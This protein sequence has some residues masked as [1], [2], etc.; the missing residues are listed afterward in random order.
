M[1][2]INLL[3]LYGL[4]WNPF[5]MSIP[6]EG[7]ANM[8]KL[9]SF[10][11]RVE[12]LVMDGGFAM[13]TGLPGTGKSVTLRMLADRLSKIPEVQ[14]GI[15]CRPQSGIADFYRELGEHFGVELRT[16]NRWGGFKGLREKWKQHIQSTLF[17]PVLLIDEAQE[18][19]PFVL[20]ELRHLASTD[21]DSNL[22]LTTVFCGDLRLQDKFRLPDLIPLGSRI[23]V[24]HQTGIASKEELMD[25]L[26]TVTEKAGN[27]HLMTKELVE[28]LAEH[29]MGNL[30]AM[31]NMA[32]TILLEGMVQEAPKLDEKLFFELYTPSK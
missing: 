2:R 16:S 5:N 8:K 7:L 28:L 6:L 1:D 15:L 12:N 20:N 13:I 29:G 9:D 21:F 11:W 17:R 31:M 24:R 27:K 4:K 10:C 26:K 18:A 23:N 25:V 3:N 22:I 30:R 32:S 14:V 19:I